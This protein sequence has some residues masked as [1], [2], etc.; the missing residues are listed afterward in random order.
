M[1]APTEHDDHFSLQHLDPRPNRSKGFPGGF[2]LEVNGT[3]N[4]SQER[5]VYL[6]IEPDDREGIRIEVRLRMHP[7]AASFDF[8]VVPRR[9]LMIN[10]ALFN[11]D[12]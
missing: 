1:L 11:V 2:V 5:W 3:G 7:A 4:R 6:E 9:A 8:P 10:S 12:I